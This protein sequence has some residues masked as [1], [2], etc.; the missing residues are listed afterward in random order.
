MKDQEM[1]ER[2]VS[3]ESIYKGKILHV[4]RDEIELPNGKRSFREY[5]EHGG[6]VAIF[7]LTKEG[8]VVLVRQYRYAHGRVFLEIPA[9]KLDRADEEPF[10][11]AVR[12]LREEVGAR[13]GR[14]TPLGVLVPSCAILTERIHMFLAEDLTFGDCAPDED[15][16]LE[17]V[18]M[19]LSSLVKMVMRGE[20]EDAKTQ[21]LALKVWQMKG[22]SQ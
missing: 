20:I 4:K 9:G 11:A 18:R 6:A 10:A 15:E 22:E 13:A 12:E 14:V 1:I 21:V 2:R 5:A 17:V 7:P 3:S 16:L 8:E 19:P